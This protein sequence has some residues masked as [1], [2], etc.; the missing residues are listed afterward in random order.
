MRLIL[1]LAVAVCA[2]VQADIIGAHLH[3][4]HES[5]T[6]VVTAPDGTTF[7]Q[8]YNNQNRGIYYMH[9]SGLTAGFYRNSYNRDTFYAGYT[10]QGPT[11]GPL[12]PAVSLTGATGYSQVHDVGKIRLQVMPSVQ[13]FGFLRYAV[14]PA[15]GGVLQHISIEKNL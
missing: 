5:E 7:T 1:A 14:A 3:S 12:R 2:P 11:W 10:W 4:R 15:K 8:R 9:N 6:H 13:I